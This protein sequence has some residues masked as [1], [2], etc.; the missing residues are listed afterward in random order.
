MGIPRLDI[1]AHQLANRHLL[2]MNLC[3]QIR[4]CCLFLKRTPDLIFSQYW[5][6]ACL[7]SS[8]FLSVSALTLSV[9]VALRKN[10][11]PRKGLRHQWPSCLVAES[12]FLVQRGTV[13]RLFS[14]RYLF[15]TYILV[16]SFTNTLLTFFLLWL[17]V[18]QLSPLGN[19]ELNIIAICFCTSSLGYN[20]K[21]LHLDF[22]QT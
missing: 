21:T 4:A 10:F 15:F 16:R 13:L 2:L 22:L 7:L 3:W 12:R 20:G 8:F 6:L 14:W 19:W 11:W 18:N 9:T 5:N 17:P 1:A